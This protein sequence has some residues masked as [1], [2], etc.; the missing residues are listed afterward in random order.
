MN[1]N[2]DKKG[3]LEQIKKL[4]IRDDA[5]MAEMEKRGLEKNYF[6]DFDQDKAR[7]HCD[8]GV[9]LY[10]SKHDILY[11]DDTASADK[12][13]IEFIK[14]EELGQNVE[15][16]E[17]RQNGDKP[18][19]KGFFDNI[20]QKIWPQKGDINNS[21]E[22]VREYRE[23]KGGLNRD[24]DLFQ[25]TTYP[26][27]S[28]DSWTSNTDT[29]PD[30]VTY[31]FNIDDTPT[32][33]FGS[34]GETDITEETI[35]TQDFFERSP[36]F[37]QNGNKIAYSAEDLSKYVKYANTNKYENINLENPINIDSDKEFRNPINIDSDKEKVTER[38][39]TLL[40][41][42]KDASYKNVGNNGN[43][44]GIFGNIGNNKGIFGN[45]GNNKSIF[46]NNGN[47]GDNDEE[48]GK[49][50]EGKEET[51]TQTFLERIERAYKK[52]GANKYGNNRNSNN[53]NNDWSKTTMGGGASNENK[54]LG[55][56]DAQKFVNKNYNK[57]DSG[58]GS[59]TEETG[60]KRVGDF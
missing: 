16:Q 56:N 22:Y 21:Q 14:K 53:G 44:K 60:M 45:N 9:Y 52:G 30:P 4:F 35:N 23:Y 1:G 27:G 49:E 57:N 51:T 48:E 50:E 32:P 40:A 26:K 19:K 29:D 8:N 59:L 5:E 46:S 37:R 55:Y 11:E 41:S 25:G 31:V 10:H 13:R 6:Q 12:A 43:N 36:K 47:M 7:T 54:H 2:G 18:E 33:D 15:K 28:Y 38:F 42:K 39:E 34:I 20:F 3:F 17:I 24:R 58:Y